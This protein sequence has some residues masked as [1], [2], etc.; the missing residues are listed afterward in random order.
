MPVARRRWGR[1]GVMGTRWHRFR[2]NMMMDIYTFTAANAWS[3]QSAAA[4]ADLK[5]TD[6]YVFATHWR[7][8]GWDTPGGDAYKEGGFYFNQ[9]LTD[10]PEE[11]L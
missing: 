11:F 1:V 4:V 6:W 10:M 3:A 2:G 9:V 8:V 7:Q 5:R